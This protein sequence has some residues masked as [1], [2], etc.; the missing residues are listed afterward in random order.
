MKTPN[1]IAWDLLPFYGE[2]SNSSP[3]SLRDIA[4]VTGLEIKTV[5]RLFQKRKLVI[6]MYS[7]PNGE[8]DVV[9]IVDSIK[10]S[11]PHHELAEDELEED[12]E[13]TRT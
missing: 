13:H 7:Y 4:E 6:L 11:K 10:Y 3:L 9:A 1:E 12:H 5:E 2:G 8:D